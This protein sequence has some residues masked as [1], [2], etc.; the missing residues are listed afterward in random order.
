MDSSGHEGDGSV[1]W[2]LLAM[3]GEP[4]SQYLILVWQAVP[5]NISYREVSN[6][7]TI[8]HTPECL[9]I[10]TQTHYPQECLVVNTILLR[11]LP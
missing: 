3:I 6:L 11:L 7:Q 4:V 9:S 2:L 5:A 8:K 1:I 10:Y